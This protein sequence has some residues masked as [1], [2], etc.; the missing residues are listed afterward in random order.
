MNLSELDI[1]PTFK[2]SVRF[3]YWLKAKNSQGLWPNNSISE[4]FVTRRSIF[5]YESKPRTDSF[6]HIEA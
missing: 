4:L 2:N 6:T 5:M 3:V 1:F